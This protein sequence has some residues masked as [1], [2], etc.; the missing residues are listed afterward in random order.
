MQEDVCRDDQE[1][2]EI[3]RRSHQRA[4]Q[5]KR[6]REEFLGISTEE[7]FAE[8]SHFENVML[9]KLSGKPSEGASCHQNRKSLDVPSLRQPG[10]GEGNS[11]SCPSSPRVSRSKESPPPSAAK[12]STESSLPSKPLLRKK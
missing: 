6:A 11:R 12:E 2:Q 10:E 1:E 9:R 5:I 7:V 8:T 4:E 3:K